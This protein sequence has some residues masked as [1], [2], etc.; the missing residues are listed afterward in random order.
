MGD[1]KK[2][3]ERLIVLE[4]KNEE[5]R[6]LVNL[7]SGLFTLIIAGVF[8]WSVVL[9]NDVATLKNGVQIHSDKI[10]ELDKTSD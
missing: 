10:V 4:T 3:L 2:L 1:D 6:R 5:S 9:G 8:S 7:L